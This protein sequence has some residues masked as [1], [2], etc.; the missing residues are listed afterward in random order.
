M[1]AWRRGGAQIILFSTGLGAPQGFPVVP[2]L[3]ITG[4]RRTAEHLQEHIDIDVSGILRGE[5]TCTEAGER[6]WSEVLAVASGTQTK[7]ELLRYHGTVN[8]YTTGPVV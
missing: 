4:N 1:Q 3:K 7:A 8:I 5:E 6:I 2:V